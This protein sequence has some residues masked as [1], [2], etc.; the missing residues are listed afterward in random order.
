MNVQLS[1]NQSTEIDTQ[2]S[3]Y[4]IIANNSSDNIVTTQRISPTSPSN[5]QGSIFNLSPRFPFDYVG[6]LVVIITST[7]SNDIPP[8]VNPVRNFPTFL[9]N[10]FFERKLS[11]QLAQVK[12]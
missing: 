8:K 7:F 1:V 6:S 10:I 11:A 9:V 2:T 12:L 3:N 4:D 5:V